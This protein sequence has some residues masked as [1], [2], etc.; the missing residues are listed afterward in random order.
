MYSAAQLKAIL[1]LMG[2]GLIQ[3]EQ[4]LIAA[5]LNVADGAVAPADLIAAADAA[6]DVL[7][8][9]GTVANLSTLISQLDAFDNGLLTAPHCN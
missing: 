2:G 7:N 6:V 8:A 5:K 4:Q 1:N 9:G 3:L